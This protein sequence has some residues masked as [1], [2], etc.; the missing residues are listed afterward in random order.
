MYTKPTTKTDEE[1]ESTGAAKLSDIVEPG[2]RRIKPSLI[3]VEPNH[4]PRKF[5]TPEMRE[6]MDGLKASIAACG[7]NLPITIRWDA[8]IGRAV[9]VDGE[10]RLRCCLELAAEGSTVRTIPFVESKQA[11]DEAQRTMLALQANQGR[12]LTQ[13]EAGSGF[14]RLVGHGWSVTEICEKVGVTRRYCEEALEIFNAP[15]A[16]KAMVQSKVVTIGR[17]IAEVRKHGSDAGTVLA[18]Q[19]AKAASTG[20]GPIRRE[21]KPPIN[22]Y[23]VLVRKIATEVGPEWD[24]DYTGEYIKVPIDLVREVLLLADAA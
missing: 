10:T 2:G 17:A 24:D 7:V 11:Y 12:P 8:A 18:P 23:Q 5:D 3:L 9:L 21:K 19:V 16:V 6:Y 4:N 13:V 15:L 20:S 14:H 22:P 1:P